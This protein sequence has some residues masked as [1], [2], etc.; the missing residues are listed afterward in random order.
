M[1][2]A[3]DLFVFVKNPPHFVRKT[4]T[5][6]CAILD[7]LVVLTPLLNILALKCVLHHFRMCYAIYIQIYQNS[8]FVKTFNIFKSIKYKSLCSSAAVINNKN[9]HHDLVRPGISLYGSCHSVSIKNKTKIKPVI[10][11]KGKILQIKIINKD[12]YIGY[13]Q[14][15]KTNK[16]IRV[17]IVG[18]GYADGISRNLSNKGKLFFK[19]DTYNIIGRVSMD[20]ITVDITKSNYKMKCGEYMDII[21]HSNDID[22]LAKSIGTIGNEILTSISKRVKRVY[23]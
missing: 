23:I 9:F 16:K 13:N 18:F 1:E 19:K 10:T 11:F 6:T 15:Y 2:H 17:A 8:N 7:L 3:S 12:E 21:N 22:K 5:V 4:L 14:T 20:S